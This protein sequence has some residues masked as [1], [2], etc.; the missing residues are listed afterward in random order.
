MSTTTVPIS[1]YDVDFVNDIKFKLPIDM[2][3]EN[4]PNFGFAIVGA[5]DPNYAGTDGTVGRLSSLAGTNS[6]DAT[7]GYN[8]SAGSGGSMRLDLMTVSAVAVPEPGS[9]SFLG[10]AIVVAATC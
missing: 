3:F 6:F 4:N 8:R 10:L 9:L 1:P 7:I 2:G 5:F